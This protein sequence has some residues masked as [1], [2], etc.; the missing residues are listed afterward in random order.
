[1]FAHNKFVVPDRE[2][3]F[4]FGGEVFFNITVNL[5][6]RGLINLNIACS[7]FFHCVFNVSDGFFAGGASAVTDSMVNGGPREIEFFVFFEFIFNKVPVAK[8][9]Q[10]FVVRAGVKNGVNLVAVNTPPSA[11][12]KGNAVG[13]A[14]G[15]FLGCEAFQVRVVHYAG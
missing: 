15:K 11:D 3:F 13:A 5:I 10:S 2:F 4:L 6:R 7:V 1:M 12:I 9:G 8:F 14:P